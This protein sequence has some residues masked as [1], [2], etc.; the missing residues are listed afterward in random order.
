[1]LG[2][3]KIGRLFGIGLYLHPTFLLMPVWVW[4]SASATG[5]VLYWELLMFCLFGCVV[6]HEFGH[7]LMARRFGIE[8]HDIT[9][10]PIGG[11]ARLERMIERPWAEFCIAL[12]GPAVNAVLACLLGLIL[13][14]F[15][16]EAVFSELEAQGAWSFVAHLLL[17]NIT[18]FVF[19][20]LPAFPMDGGRVLRALLSHW[21]GLVRATELATAI[22]FGMLVVFMNRFAVPLLYGETP[23]Q[24]IVMLALGLFVFVVGL[25]EMWSVQQR[26]AQQQFEAASFIV[27]A[28]G[29]DDME[30]SWTFPPSFEPLPPEDANFSGLTWD[31]KSRLWIEWQNGFPVQTTSLEHGSSIEHHLVNR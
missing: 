24:G 30:W 14:L 21:L 20:L 22:G 29:E 25:R 11:V 27:A 2:A 1:M 19:N 23:L 5:A 28:S 4:V 31:A 26:E 15:A 12:A 9:L 13:Y 3:W 16:G 7:A 17:A 6:L 18:L 8:T 10:L